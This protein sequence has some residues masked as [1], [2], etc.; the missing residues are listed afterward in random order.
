MRDA[1]GPLASL[2]GLDDGTTAAGRHF[3]SAALS[4]PVPT[5]LN[6]FLLAWKRL[7]LAD[8]VYAEE[9]VL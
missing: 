3:T 8:L 4:S 9:L 6:D 2:F 7:H 1:N 5:S